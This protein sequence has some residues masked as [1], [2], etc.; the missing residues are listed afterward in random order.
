MTRRKIYIRNCWD[1]LPTR[2]PATP[3]SG[4]RNN[5]GQMAFTFYHLYLAR[6]SN[7]SSSNKVKRIQEHGDLLYNDE[8]KCWK[9][10]G[11]YDKPIV[12]R[13][14]ECFEIKVDNSYIRCRIQWEDDWILFFTGAIFYLLPKTIYQVRN[15]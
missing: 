5:E 14:G 3:Q 9:V 4:I 1:R 8:K 11:I 7:F 2:F 15:I 13:G 12:L 6:K 10:Q